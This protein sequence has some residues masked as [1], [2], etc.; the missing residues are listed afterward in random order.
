VSRVRFSGAVPSSMAENSVSGDWAATLALVGDLAG[1]RAIELV[2][3]G[4]L[5]FTL[6]YDPALGVAFLDPG[7]ATDY[8]G[9]TLNGGDPRLAFGLRYT[10][11][12]GTSETDTTTL[13]VTVT[14]TD[15]TPP[16]ALRF[17]SGGRIGA[18]QLGG[19]IG[20]LQVDDPDSAGPF[21][22]QIIGWDDWLF[23]F[24]GMVLKLRDGFNLG[25]DAIPTKSLIVAV[26]DS[27]QTAAFILDIQVTDSNEPPSLPVLV[28]AASIEGIAAFGTGRAVT[29]RD[30]GGF[31]AATAAGDAARI[32]DPGETAPILLSGAS[33]LEFAEGWLDFA[34]DGPAIRATLLYRAIE[35]A[36]PDAAAVAQLVAAREA[37]AGWVAIAAGLLA[38][39]V[40]TGVTA[41]VDAAYR[42]ALGRA[43]D[44]GELAV[45]IALLNVGGNRAQF[46]VEL[47]FSDAALA[48]AP[49]HPNGIWV[50]QPLGLDTAPEWLADRAGIGVAPPVPPPQDVIFL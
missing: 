41:F 32:I 36:A 23:E 49:A 24:D 29:L 22:F 25:L 26:S 12:D 50:A 14:D 18:D 8:E 37:G 43:P 4:A 48:N 46:A 17:A 7:A 13:R 44:A 2:G 10:Y 31:L 21:S 40:P 27:R 47:A 34:T 16:Q 15:D 28:E 42:A 38:D 39:E 33:R 30:P 19:V 9:L 6:R 5:F 3:P 1:L 20:R 11:T 35:G 45:G